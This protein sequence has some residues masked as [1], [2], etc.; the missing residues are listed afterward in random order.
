[1]ANA[2]V[3]C[4]QQ[5]LDETPT[6][7][8]KGWIQL[9]FDTKLL[10]KVVIDAKGVYKE[11]NKVVSLLKFKIDPINLALLDG[12]LSDLVDRYYARS[13]VIYGSLLLQNPKLSDS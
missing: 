7:N 12:P 13:C 3:Q 6:L 8:E 2:L 4:F 1:M 9:L 5:Y 11:F 10:S